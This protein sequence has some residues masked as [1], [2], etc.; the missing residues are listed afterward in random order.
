[1]NGMYSVTLAEKTL[2][3]VM[4]QLTQLHTTDL[5]V[6]PVAEDIIRSKLPQENTQLKCMD[7]NAPPVVLRK[8]CKI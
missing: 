7:T 6:C 3:W 2:E 4:L 1:M 8:D 5:P